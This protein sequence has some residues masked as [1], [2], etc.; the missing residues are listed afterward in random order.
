MNIIV[1]SKINLDEKLNE[2][3]VPISQ[4]VYKEKNQN[5]NLDEKIKNDN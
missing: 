3:N 4:S 5:D 2:M 1:E